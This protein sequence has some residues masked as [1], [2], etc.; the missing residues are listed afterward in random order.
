MVSLNSK[1]CS[2]LVRI[3]IRKDNTDNKVFKREFYTK[4]SRKK[5]IEKIKYCKFLVQ[6]AGAY[7]RV[8]GK[9]TSKNLSSFPFFFVL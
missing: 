7:Q 1:F 8:S 9:Q 6:F 5:G 4:E 3:L 2:F